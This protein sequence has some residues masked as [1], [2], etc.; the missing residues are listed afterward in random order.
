[1]KLSSRSFVLQILTIGIMLSF[2][3]RVY[4]EAPREELVH[5]YVLLQ[6]ANHDYNG[7]RAKALEHVEEAAKALNLK[8]QGDANDRERQWKSDQMLTEA[9]S[10]L[11]QA[12]D[13]FEAHDRERAVKH[14][15]RAIEQIDAAIGKKR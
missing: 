2:G 4:A 8:L 6:H 5:A 12:R 7:H 3:V 15:D 9:R 1:M 14:V 13:N 11:S 10:L